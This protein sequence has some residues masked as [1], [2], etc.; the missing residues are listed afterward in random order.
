MLSLSLFLIIQAFPLSVLS[1]GEENTDVNI[2]IKYDYETINSNSLGEVTDT[3][4]IKIIHILINVF[5][6]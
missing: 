4:I 5:F 2:D 3:K 1:E 6:S